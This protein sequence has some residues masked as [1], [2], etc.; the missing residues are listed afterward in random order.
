MSKPVTRIGPEAFDDGRLT[1]SG[2]W[3]VAFLA[4]WCPFCREFEPLFNELGDS[5][6]FGLLVADVTAQ[7]SPLWERFEIDVVPTVLV[8]RDGRPVFRMDGIPGEGLGPAA[9]AA[10]RTAGEARLAGGAAR[11]TPALGKE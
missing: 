11:A 4:D 5:R 9:I 8:F 7:E 10:V 1:R 6:S 3:A 2:S